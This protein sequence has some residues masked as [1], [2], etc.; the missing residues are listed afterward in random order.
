MKP[1]VPKLGS[2][3]MPVSPI[4]P[5]VHTGIVT[6]VVALVPDR[7][8]SSPVISVTSRRPSG[9]KAIAVGEPSPVTVAVSAKPAM[10][11]P[12]HARPIEAVTAAIR[13]TA[14]VRLC[15]DTL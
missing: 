8:L 3:A 1:L 4:S 7:T 9:R 12:A 13:N 5:P 6:S 11:L 15:I 14:A 10:G 2:T